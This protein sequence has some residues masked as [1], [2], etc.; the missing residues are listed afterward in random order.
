MKIE[1]SHDLLAKK[2]YD[3]ASTE[4]KMLIKISNFIKNRFAYFKENNVLLSKDDLN[5]IRPYLS[6]ITLEKH[7]II[8]IQRS[9]QTISLRRALVGAL[10]IAIIFIIAHFM[11]RTEK[12]KLKN[13]ERLAKEV[14]KYKAIEKQ[15][16]QLSSALVKSREGLDTT[17]EALRLALLKLQ[18]QND[19]LVY[20]YA[21][22]KVKQDYSKDQILRDLHIAQSSKLSELAASIIKKDKK[23][24]FKL[25]AK[26]WQLNPNNQQAMQIIYQCGGA[27]LETPLSKQRTRNI[28]KA[29]KKSLGE[30]S[31]KEMKAIFN[32]E[33][34]ITADRDKELSFTS[35]IKEVTQKPIPPPSKAF[36]PQQQM[37]SKIKE[38]VEVIQQQ[39]K[40]QNTPIKLPE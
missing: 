33:N 7:E 16:K 1:L 9:Q 32:P 14:Q 23:H 19:T 2:I 12:V 21:A 39:I 4:D 5:Y 17:K 8:F 24:A 31:N 34:N 15:A 11:N 20:S 35:Q 30:L 27:T 37:S 36:I 26:A 18:T 10:A 3:K 13:Q 25:S 6:L 28:I 29:N 38:Q 40:Q 22:Y